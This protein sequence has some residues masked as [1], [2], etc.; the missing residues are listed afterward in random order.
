VRDLVED[1]LG[2]EAENALLL[3]IEEKLEAATRERLGGQKDDP[4]R[5]LEPVRAQL[6][7]QTAPPTQPAPAG[8]RA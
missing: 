6:A 2:A 3:Q 7:G 8:N 1:G 4:A 5:A